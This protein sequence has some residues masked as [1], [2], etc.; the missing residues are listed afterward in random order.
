MT[1]FLKGKLDIHHPHCSDGREIVT[2]S[3][4]DDA[5]SC[6]VIEIEVLLETFAHALFGMSRQ[7]CKF[8]IHPKNVGMVREV[9]DVMVPRPEGYEKITRE[10]G[11]KLAAEH[12]VDGWMLRDPSDFRNGHN[13]G[14]FKTVRV[15]L[16]RYVKPII[17]SAAPDAGERDA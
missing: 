14:P 4:I 15:G 17:A 12:L 6:E 7:D 11:E 13:W 16:I 3:V 1:T 8:E 5:S 9:K 10:E 2:I